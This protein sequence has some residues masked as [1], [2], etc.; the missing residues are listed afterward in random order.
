MFITQSITERGKWL[1][2]LKRRILMF[3]QLMVRENQQLL[4]EEKHALARAVATEALACVPTNERLGPDLFFQVAWHSNSI[5]Y[6]GVLLR[7]REGLVEVFVV[8]RASDDPIPAWR[9]KLHIPGVVLLP[10]EIPD[11]ESLHMPMDRLSGKEF[12]G[13]ITSHRYAGESWVVGRRGPILSKIFVVECSCN[14]AE[15]GLGMWVDAKNPPTDVMEYHVKEI[16]PK[17]VSFFEST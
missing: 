15:Q 12:G 7:R 13:L 5:S 17:A 10:G 4:P 11:N 8:P 14:P 16:I 1:E 2:K 3:F 6:E 9:E